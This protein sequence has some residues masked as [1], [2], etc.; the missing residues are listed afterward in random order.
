MISKRA[1]EAIYIILLFAVFILLGNVANNAWLGYPKGD[2]VFVWMGKARFLFD[3]F[4]RIPSWD[5]ATNLGT[6]PFMGNGISPLIYWLIALVTKAFLIKDVAITFHFFFLLSFFAIGL[7][8]FFLGKV[9]GIPSFLSFCFALLFWTTPALWTIITGGA[10]DR[11]FYL[12]L[13]FLCII[14]WVKHVRAINK[15]N[16]REEVR[17]EILAIITYA[18]TAVSHLFI[19]FIALSTVF[20]SYLFEKKIKV[21][22]KVFALVILLSSWFYYPVA[23]KFIEVNRL[24]VFKHEPFNV[25]LW[26]LF[27]PGDL[28]SHSL[29]F[30]YIPFALLLAAGL[31]ALLYLRLRRSEEAKIRDLDRFPLSLAIASGILS[32]YFIVIT[33]DVE[34]KLLPNYLRVCATYNGPDWL[35]VT[36]LVF[37]MST[38]SFLKNNYS[39]LRRIRFLLPLTR[40]LTSHCAQAIFLLLIVL[41]ASHVQWRTP[42]EHSIADQ[43]LTRILAPLA[44]GAASEFRVATDQLV[45][46]RITN[47]YFPN[48]QIVGGRF[49]Y[50]TYNPYF[51][52]VI[53]YAVIY[54]AEEESTINRVYFED[55]PLFA[56][57]NYGGKDNWFP[58]LFWLDWTGSKFIALVKT[59]ENPID[60]TIHGYEARKQYFEKVEDGWLA[61]A[62]LYQNASPIAIATNA[63][64]VGVI[65]SEPAEQ[66]YYYDIIDILSYLNINSKYIIPIPID[67]SKSKEL[68]GKIKQFDV[69]IVSAPQLKNE[70]VTNFLKQSNSKRVVVFSYNLTENTPDLLKVKK[71][72]VSIV[73]T[74]LSIRELKELGV[75][76]SYEFLK[77]IGYE[78]IE[79]REVTV[80]KNVIKKV[81]NPTAFYIQFEKNAKGELSKEEEALTVSLMPTESDISYHQVNVQ[82]VIP[83]NIELPPEMGEVSFLVWSSDNAEIGLSLES[84][85]SSAYVDIGRNIKVE[86]GKI[87]QIKVPLNAF[88]VFHE[89]RFKYSNKFTLCLVSRSDEKLLFKIWDMKISYFM[90]GILKLDKPIRLGENGFLLLTLEPNPPFS[91]KLILETSNGMVAETQYS[92]LSR[93]ETSIFIPLSAFRAKSSLIFDRFYV[94]HFKVYATQS[95]EEFAIKKA[96]LIL[97]SPMAFEPLTTEWL[98]PENLLIKSLTPCSFKGIIVKE[99]YT[100]EWYY[101]FDFK[102]YTAV[103]QAGPSVIYLPLPSHGRVDG[104][105]LTFIEEPYCRISKVVSLFSIFTIISYYIIRLKNMLEH[106]T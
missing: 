62:F 33:F 90:P 6:K 29:A 41:S 72:D 11:I 50:S 68:E 34:N 18:V 75:E 32:T 9:L 27:W 26:W 97:V 57:K 15:R 60:N 10:Y 12:P 54:P 56:W 100:S 52:D 1:Q 81:W 30:L 84:S 80:L 88:S 35:S 55:R 61:T 105:S 64:L 48:L 63:S 43:E 21:L 86:G 42:M 49:G 70:K 25:P 2:D 28:Y 20:L 5:P 91:G 37:I 58:T 85:D 16:K 59:I 66:A 39:T 17:W 19:A 74:P 47:Y 101:S 102:N 38:L 99:T 96:L 40:L 106:E 8:I 14:A 89:K 95:N 82:T 92:T 94:D 79:V 46:T 67:I 24:Q 78:K 93:H 69:L 73:K 22:V 36:L 98:D 103:V 3:N 31:I 87:N 45:V 76:G 104:I 7:S 51:K 13:I 4:P 44:K 65:M 23:M 71:N 53:R 83:F 77:L